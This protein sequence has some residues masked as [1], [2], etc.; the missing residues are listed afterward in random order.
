MTSVNLAAY[1]NGHEIA[2][3]PF[4]ASTQFISWFS[5]GTR[6]SFAGGVPYE[7]CSDPGS[8]RGLRPYVSWINLPLLPTSIAPPPLFNSSSPSSTGLGGRSPPSYQV[9][10]TAG[11]LP[12]AGNSYI[13]IVACGKQT[14]LNGVLT[15]S[16]VVG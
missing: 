4:A 10:L 16:I 11:M 13:V 9:S 15:V 1:S 14:P 3:R 6:A 2:V 5:S 8:R 12:R 7:S